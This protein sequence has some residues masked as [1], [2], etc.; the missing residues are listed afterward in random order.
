ENVSSYLT[1]TAS[2]VPEWEFLTEVVRRADC[3]VLLDVNNIY[4]SSFN[5]RF[6]PI[7]YLNGVPVERVAQF[8]LAGHTD[9][10][11]HLLDTHDHD[12]PDPVWRLYEEAVRRF[13]PVSTLIERDDRIP[14]FPETAAEAEHARGIQN[15]ANHVVAQPHSTDLLRADHRA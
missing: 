15:N 2:T 10:G 13:G 8:H 7:D 11:N 4:V 5:H 3:Y 12:V 1:Y 14:E 9:N 6:D